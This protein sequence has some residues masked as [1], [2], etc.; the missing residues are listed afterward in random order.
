MRLKL[1]ARGQVRR[2]CVGSPAR[3][4]TTNRAPSIQLTRIAWRELPETPSHSL[5]THCYGASAD[6]MDLVA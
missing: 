3:R 6:K 5:A 4:V 2:N 1:T